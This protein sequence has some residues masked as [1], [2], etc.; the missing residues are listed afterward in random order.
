MDHY[1]VFLT[2]SLT[3]LSNDRR[4]LRHSGFDLEPILQCDLSG[5]AEL[6]HNFQ[7]IAE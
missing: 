5:L 7:E 3:I 1:Y 4:G 2:L 6:R